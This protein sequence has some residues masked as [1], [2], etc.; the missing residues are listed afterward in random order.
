[1][2]FD[3]KKNEEIERAI[4]GDEFVDRQISE[5]K[6]CYRCWKPATKFIPK[7]QEHYCGFC[8][9]FLTETISMTLSKGIIKL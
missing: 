7:T 2:S 1:M 9:G 3:D 4:M 5:H 6:K 8:Y